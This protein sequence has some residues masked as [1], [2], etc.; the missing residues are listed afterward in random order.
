LSDLEETNA[1]LRGVTVDT[2]EPSV[3][4]TFEIV[5]SDGVIPV[6]LVSVDRL[7]KSAP[8]GGRE[9]F[10]LIFRAS[11]DRIIPQM[12]WTVRNASTGEH[13]FLAVPVGGDETGTLYQVVFN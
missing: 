5:F 10:S 12:N 2:F 7:E 4:D 11:S 13:T 9:P 6:E 8:S 3:T 1:R